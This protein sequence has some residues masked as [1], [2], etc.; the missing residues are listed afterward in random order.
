M[1]A[2]LKVERA[3]RY[4]P[5]DLNRVHEERDVRRSIRLLL[6]GTVLTR[7]VSHAEDENARRVREE[8]ER[9]LHQMVG[10]PPTRVRVDFAAL[11]EPN[12]TLEAA[13]F[14]LDGRPLY[15]PPVSQLSKEGT[16]LVW[17][18]D[19]KPGK[20]TVRALVVYANATSVVVSEEG[21]HRW[22]VSGEVGFEVNA[23]IEVQV[24]V[25]PSRDPSQRDISKRLRLSLPAKPVML[26]Q[27][28][29]GKMPEPLVASSPPIS[30]SEAAE[31]A[32]QGAMRDEA[33]PEVRRKPKAKAHR[34]SDRPRSAPVESLADPA[35]GELL[36]IPAVRPAPVGGAAPD[37]LLA[38]AKVA[39]GDPPPPTDSPPAEALPS[40]PVDAGLVAVSIEPPAAEGAGAMIW[41]SIGGVGGLGVVLA[42]VLNSARRRAPP[43][44]SHE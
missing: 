16:H 10:S 37:E 41:L 13:S 7:A 30:P 36:A 35:E 33:A 23:G 38:R 25:V 17:S 18:G 3:A 9:Q 20:H 8:L 19:V 28:D 27:L 29:D 26:A 31:G 21:G 12:F 42:L 24:Q 22:K 2:R 34:S 4:Q 1:G 43:P 44:S 32:A 14:A 39:P 5:I 15:A 11:D 6:L 40:I